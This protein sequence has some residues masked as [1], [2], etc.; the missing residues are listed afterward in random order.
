MF[1]IFG[2]LSF[3]GRN[4]FVNELRLS[5]NYVELISSFFRSDRRDMDLVDRRRYRGYV[6]FVIE[7]FFLF[8]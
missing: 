4:F 3:W 8:M 7:F 6:F 2:G 5:V 1:Y